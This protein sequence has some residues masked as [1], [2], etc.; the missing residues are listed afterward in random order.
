M[1]ISRVRDP[2]FVSEICRISASSSVETRVRM[3]VAM[4]PSR[5]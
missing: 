1:S 5:R 2:K 4:A 3:L